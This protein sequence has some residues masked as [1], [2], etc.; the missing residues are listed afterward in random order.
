MRGAGVSSIS[1]TFRVEKEEREHEVPAL[2]ERTGSCL[3]RLQSTCRNSSKSKVR[4]QDSVT[5]WKF[6]LRN[7]TEPKPGDGSQIP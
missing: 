4:W 2:S 3:E 1:A 5:T 7:A 6:F